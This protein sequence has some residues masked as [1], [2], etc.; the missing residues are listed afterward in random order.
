MSEKAW[1]QKRSLQDHGIFGIT[2][3]KVHWVSATYGVKVDSFTRE[4]PKSHCILRPNCLYCCILELSSHLIPERDVLKNNMF[5]SFSSFFGIFIEIHKKIT[6]LITLNMSTLLLN[7][8][9]KNATSLLEKT[10][11]F[12]FAWHL[13][14]NMIV[15]LSY[16]LLVWHNSFLCVRNVPK[17]YIVQIDKLSWIAVK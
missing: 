3:R 9:S 13:I 15:G 11:K 16:F 12:I 6:K 10:G 17:I 4:K 14:S 1:N 5:I 2:A 8:P 7:P